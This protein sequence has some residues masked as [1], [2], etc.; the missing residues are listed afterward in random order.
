MANEQEQD[1]QINTLQINQNTMAEALKDF[2]KENGERF[3][4]VDKSFD[5]IKDLIKE[6]ANGKAN[7]WVEIFLLWAGAIIGAGLLTFL[8]SLI[9]KAIIAFK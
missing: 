2:K 3:D 9:Y 6:V 8:G 5:E 7:K 4:K 1:I